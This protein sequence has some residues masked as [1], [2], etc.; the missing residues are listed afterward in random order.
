MAFI[1]IDRFMCASMSCRVTFLN[2]HRMFFTAVVIAAK[3]QDDEVYT[4]DVSA[5]MGGIS[6]RELNSLEAIFLRSL[7]WRVH[8]SQRELSEGIEL[9]RLHDSLHDHIGST[10]EPLTMSASEA[11]SLLPRRA[12]NDAASFKISRDLAV[13]NRNARRH[14]HCVLGGCRRRQRRCATARGAE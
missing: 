8:I 6:S 5:A 7:D 3:I 2:V 1:Y 9:L 13:A 10:S 4:N 14:H 11:T 12:P